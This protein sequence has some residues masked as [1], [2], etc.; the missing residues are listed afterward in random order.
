MGLAGSVSSVPLS[1]MQSWG[2]CTHEELWRYSGVGNGIS[3]AGLCGRSN[4]CKCIYLSASG[5]TAHPGRSK[6]VLL[7]AMHTLCFL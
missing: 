7:T 3:Q 6:K 2:F 4:A 5:C 1:L